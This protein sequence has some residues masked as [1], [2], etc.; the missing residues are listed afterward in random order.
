MVVNSELLQRVWFLLLERVTLGPGVRVTVHCAV[1][2]PQL[3]LL[4][5]MVIVPA[6]VGMPE[7]SPVSGL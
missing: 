4:V 3:V 1:A 5:E 6:S 2:V 7:I